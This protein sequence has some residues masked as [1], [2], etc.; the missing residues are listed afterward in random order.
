MEN[1]TFI[2]GLYDNETW[3]F[4]NGEEWVSDVREANRLD[5]TAAFDLCEKFAQEN[6]HVVIFR[7]KIFEESD[8]VFDF[9]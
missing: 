3:S 5:K 2:L 9:S 8:S 1:E 4:F 7:S 6:L